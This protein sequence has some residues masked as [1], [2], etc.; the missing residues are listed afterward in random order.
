[1]DKIL[2]ARDCGATNWRLY[3]VG[4]QVEAGVARMSGVPLPVADLAASFQ[5]AVVDVLVGKTIQ[6][7]KA[8]NVAEILV[9]KGVLA[10]R[11]LRIMIQV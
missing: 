7:A 1:L 6:A 3:R 2:F 8:F 9:A 4:Y 5:A 11:A 10:N